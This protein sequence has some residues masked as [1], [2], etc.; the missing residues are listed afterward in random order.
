MISFFYN[1]I[2][3]SLVVLYEN[4]Y[5]ITNEILF[6]SDF[7]SYSI[8]ISIFVV[9]VLFNLLTYPLYKKADIIQN[10]ARLKKEKMSKWVEHIKKVFK[11]DER[12]FILSTY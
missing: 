3:T 1:L 8:L 6:L 12:Y 9:S 4:A 10:E 2:I 7:A 11:G 5:R